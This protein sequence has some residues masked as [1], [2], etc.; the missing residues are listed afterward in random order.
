MELGKYNYGRGCSVA[1]IKFSF[2]I[3]GESGTFLQEILSKTKTPHNTFGRALVQDYINKVN[4]IINNKKMEKLNAV[5][6]TGINEFRRLTN[7]SKT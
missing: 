2:T 3:S 6:P 5:K 4:N 7:G 1:R